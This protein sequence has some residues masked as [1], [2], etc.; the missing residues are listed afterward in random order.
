[1]NCKRRGKR[2]YY[3]AQ[4]L[5]ELS[6]I[7]LTGENSRQII[8]ILLF[9]VGCTSECPENRRQDFQVSRSWWHT[10]Y[11]VRR[12]SFCAKLIVRPWM[13][14]QMCHER[15]CLH[16][17]STSKEGTTR[18]T[19]AL[20]S[21]LRSVPNIRGASAAS[22]R[23]RDRGG[24]IEWKYPR[25]V[26]GRVHSDRSR[27]KLAKLRESH[28]RLIFGEIRRANLEINGLW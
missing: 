5:T 28:P 8:I 13:C 26:R 2:R 16:V 7:K 14:G 21:S 15:R 6:P 27:V 19:N 18:C 11:S 25:L 9:L 3:C 23:S 12:G 1:M 24:S 17:Y 10:L 20:S 22:Q 4:S